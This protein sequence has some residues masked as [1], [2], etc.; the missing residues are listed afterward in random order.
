[1]IVLD[2][3]EMRVLFEGVASQPIPAIARGFAAPVIVDDGQGHNQRLAQMAHDPDPYTRWEAGQALAR[4]AILSRA[5]ALTGG[6]PPAPLGPFLTALSR[7]I[8]RAQEDEAFAALALRLPELPELIQIA[9]APDPDVL[10][11]ARQAVR[12]EIARNLRAK[13]EPLASRRGEA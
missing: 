8:D 5:A 3:A 9:D 11:Q 10:H 6:H 7:E 13:L 4:E 12:A 1:H 2:R